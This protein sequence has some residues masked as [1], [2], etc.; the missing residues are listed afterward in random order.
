[1]IEV[2]LSLTKAEYL[3]GQRLFAQEMFR[4]SRTWRWPVAAILLLHALWMIVHP[5]A[6]G[7]FIDSPVFTFFSIVMALFVLFPGVLAHLGSA[8][9]YNVEKEI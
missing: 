8:K 4:K 5:H 3:E 1:M 9:R 7:T 2:Y 6:P